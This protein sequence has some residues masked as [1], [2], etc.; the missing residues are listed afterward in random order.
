MGTVPG[1]ALLLYWLYRTVTASLPYFGTDV[2]KEWP[3]FSAINPLSQTLFSAAD[4]GN[5]LCSKNGGADHNAFF[6]QAMN[7]IVH[8]IPNTITRCQNP[9]FLN[10]LK[11]LVS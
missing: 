7:E 8:S 11:T 9:V 6:L 3:A 5:F 1:I 4:D 10:P 2:L